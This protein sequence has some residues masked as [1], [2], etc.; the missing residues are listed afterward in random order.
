MRK[1]CL[2]WRPEQLLVEQKY[3]PG[4][5]VFRCQPAVN[6]IQQLDILI[7]WRRLPAAIAFADIII[8]VGQPDV[9]I[10]HRRVFLGVFHNQVRE[11]IH[12]VSVVKA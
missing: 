6:F 2:D 1:P 5:Q 7:R 4:R 9:E 8:F 12:R 11:G 3:N 10:V